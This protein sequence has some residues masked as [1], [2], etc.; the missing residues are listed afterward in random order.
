MPNVRDSSL[1]YAPCDTPFVLKN[2][3]G[4]SVVCLLVLLSF[5]VV[6]V[7]GPSIVMGFND[8]I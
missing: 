4:R 3:P 8:V 1:W 7:R 6:I 5:V 2:L